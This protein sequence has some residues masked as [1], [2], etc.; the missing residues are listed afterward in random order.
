MSFANYHTHTVYCDGKDT[1]EQLV[2]QALALGCPAIGF[3]GHGVAPY[4]DAAMTTERE[5]QYRAEVRRLQQVYAGQITILC[6]V[7]QEYLSDAPTD[8]YDYV[9]GG[10]HY[11]H[12]GDD[13]RTVDWTPEILRSIVDDWFGGDWY[14]MAEEY[15][16]QVGDLYEKTHC[17]VVAHF[18]LIEKFNEDGSL[19]DR[20]HPRYR[21]AALGALA[22][23]R[24]AP[25]IFEINTGAI[26]RGYRT[27]P[28]PADFLLRAMQ[29]A[30]VPLM[31]GADCHDRRFLLCGFAQYAPLVSPASFSPA[32][33]LDFT[34]S[35]L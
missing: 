3:S 28:Y 18:D 16:A 20:D 35:G 33:L 15:Y 6:G 9:I 32:F 1:P 10:V 24:T 21:A 26:A 30:G 25:V 5:A 34:A 29:D 19:F 31:L 22:Q 7:E 14:T 11:L 17:R 13:Y 8:G 23:L 2:Q 4:D 27:T 12:R